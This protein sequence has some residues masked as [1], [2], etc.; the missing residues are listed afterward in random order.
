MPLRVRHTRAA[1][2]DLRAIW[3]YISFDS[4]TA[5]D[6]QLRRI[7]GL[8]QT[9]ADAPLIARARPDLADGLRSFPAGRHVIFFDFDSTTLRIVRVIDS[10]RQIT[11]DMFAA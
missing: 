8:I 7:A 5:A 2:R 6:G 10:A 9:L 11:P 4:E 3:N 1:R